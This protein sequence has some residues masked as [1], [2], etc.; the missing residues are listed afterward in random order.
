MVRLV[1]NHYTLPPLL[2]MTPLDG[3]LSLQPAF[4][5]KLTLLSSSFFWARSISKMPLV[6]T[7]TSFTHEWSRF[8]IFFSW[9][10]V[11][12]SILLIHKVRGLLHGAYRGEASAAGLTPLQSLISKFSILSASHTQLFSTHSN[13]GP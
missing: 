7:D 13:G 12:A 5:P 10:E 6:P 3:G 11:G 4:H 2:G 1:K 9:L 8:E